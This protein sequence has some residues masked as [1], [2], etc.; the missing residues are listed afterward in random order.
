MRQNNR[1]LM[2]FIN[3][4]GHADTAYFRP[5]PMRN[6]Q[7]SVKGEVRSGHA[8]RSGQTIAITQNDGYAEFTLPLLEEYELLDLG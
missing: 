8:L 6:I 1:R 5:I 2:H 3:L 4:S 7:V